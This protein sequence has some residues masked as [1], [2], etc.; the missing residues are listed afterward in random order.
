M[1][2]GGDLLEAA[3]R[4]GGQPEDWLDL[5][6]GI[7][8]QP[9]PFTHPD[10]N[11]WARL[12]QAARVEKLKTT[13]R[14]AYGAPAEAAIL[15]AP[16]TQ[17]LIQSLPLLFPEAKVAILGPTYTEHAI[18]WHRT[19][20]SVD[21]ATT[22]IELENAT[23]AVIVNPNNPDGRVVPQT[24]IRELADRIDARGGLV[25]VDEA[26]ADV[27]PDASV[28]EDC[29]HSGLLVLR[30]FGKFFGLAGVRLGFAIGA[31]TLINRLDE[32][33]G[34]WAVPGPTIEI[35]IE[36]IGDAAWIERS[37]LDYA[38]AA[39]GLDRVLKA[40]GHEVVGGTSLFRLTRH[41]H[42]RDVHEAL[43]QRQILTRVFL[44]EPNLIRYGLPPH[45]DFER[46]AEALSTMAATAGRAQ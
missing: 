21:H 17:C 45:K 40:A 3:A 22:L 1:K 14:V 23:I 18:N 25:V 46:F 6:T 36:A 26:F 31:T 33:I 11:S 5:S 2:H 41:P 39:A 13:A 4:F 24:A 28:I 7:A 37:R 34:P 19:A 20:H 42:A 16:G 30:S 12:P 29:G 10:Q 27:D 35:G 15:P 38:A 43:A 44:D 32:H 9:Y 8:P